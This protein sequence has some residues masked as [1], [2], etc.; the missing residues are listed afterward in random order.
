MQLRV[1]A[2]RTS[3]TGLLLAALSIEQQ[4]FNEDVFPQIGYDVDYLHPE[5]KD[6]IEKLANEGNFPSGR[7][8]SIG[9]VKGDEPKIALHTQNSGK[10]KEY[11]EYIFDLFEKHPQ[12]I[13]VKEEG[14]Y[15][16][17]Y[18][19]PPDYVKRLFEAN[20]NGTIPNVTVALQE[21]FKNNDEIDIETAVKNILNS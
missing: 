11:N 5:Y 6:A 18:F 2:P 9:Y 13:E 16:K 14:E 20:D 4:N 10:W 8:V 3:V 7:F 15:A 12:Y 17:F 1:T 21:Q 19:T